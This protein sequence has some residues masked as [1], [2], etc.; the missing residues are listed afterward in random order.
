MDTN[1]PVLRLNEDGKI[2]MSPPRVSATA[3]KDAIS[4]CLLRGVLDKMYDPPQRFGWNILGTAI[5]SAIQHVATDDLD[6]DQ[7]IEHAH[8]LV[9]DKLQEWAKAG[10]S[11]RYAQGRGIDTIDQDIEGMLAGW[12]RD[13]H[14]DS[15]K[16]LPL[17]AEHE[18]P[19]RAEVELSRPGLHTIVDAVFD[20]KGTPGE[21][22][23][24]DWKTGGT[25]KADTQQLHFYQWMWPQF[26]S[27]D[28]ISGAWFHHLVDGSR[29]HADDYPGD[30]WMEYKY[31]YAK[32]IINDPTL[33]MM[34]RPHWVCGRADLCPHKAVCPAF[35]GDLHTLW[36]NAKL[37]TYDEAKGGQQ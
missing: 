29:Q 34:P 5:H 9:W 6:L 13:V 27:K 11:V 31:L 17:Y 36:E 37:I 8:D 2:P 14:P 7:A 25:P 12:F 18:W 16:R 33:R 22:S 24:V 28:R 15:G 32:T 20:L 1:P 30:D 4:G 3:M 21:V 19:F 26:H 23:I 10:K 35:D